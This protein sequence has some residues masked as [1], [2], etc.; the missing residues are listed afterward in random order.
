M[1]K[2]KRVTEDKMV[3]WHHQCNGHELEQTPGDGEG[4]GRPAVLQSMWSQRA[5]QDL[6][7]EQQ[8]KTLFSLPSL[9]TASLSIYQ[10]SRES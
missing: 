9:H 3:G 5:G 1:Q 10:T 4:T 6:V 2:E 7:T 8:T